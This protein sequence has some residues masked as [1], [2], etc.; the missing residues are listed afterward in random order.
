M[1]DEKRWKSD[2][3]IVDDGECYCIVGPHGELFG[4]LYYSIIIGE[5]FRRRI[6]SLMAEK[7]L[8][9]FDVMFTV[10]SDS[11]EPNSTFTGVMYRLFS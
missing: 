6:K 11:L 10:L 9:C 2:F 4:V 1:T 8:W 3:A 5:L 7:R